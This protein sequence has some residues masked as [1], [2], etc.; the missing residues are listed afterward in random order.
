[1]T[2]IL[3][4]IA[5]AMGALASPAGAQEATRYIDPIFTSISE[6]KDI[7]FGSAVNNLGDR[8][9]L[10]LDLFE[11]TG[12]DATDRA[13]MIWV[14]G[15]GF[16][17]GTKNDGNMRALAAG[18]A[19]RG[20]VSASINYRVRPNGTPGSSSNQEL[21]LASVT[22]EYPEQI[23]DAQV[24]AQAAVRWFRANAASLGVDEGLIMMGGGS[25]GAVTSLE[26]LFN[27]SDPGDSGNPDYDSSIRAAV[28]LWG[29]SDVRRIEPETGPIL[30]YHGTNDT[31]V[32]YALGVETCAGTTAMLNRCKL[33]TYPGEGHGPWK[34]REEILL[35]STQWLYEQIISASPSI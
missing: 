22:G 3:L 30:M 35:E 23:R 27:P 19:Q 29:A 31:T 1:M 9:D 11:P 33:V 5:L 7:V 34:H 18:Y 14:H 21:I 20:W 17:S 4:T 28:S 25:A 13:V 15:G 32:P 10:T 2:R 24:D 8:I 6:T 12:D 26:V 16:K